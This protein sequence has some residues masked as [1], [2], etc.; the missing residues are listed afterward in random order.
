[1]TKFTIQECTI[2]IYILQ[3]VFHCVPGVNRE[4]CATLVDKIN[5]SS[6]SSLHSPDED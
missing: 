4:E 1:M 6:T 3:G 5:S 2:V